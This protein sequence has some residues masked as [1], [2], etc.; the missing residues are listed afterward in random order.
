MY[1]PI[2]KYVVMKIF[3]AVG[4]LLYQNWGLEI[5]PISTDEYERC[6]PYLCSLTIMGPPHPVACEELIDA[7]NIETHFVR[8]KYNHG[9]GWM[10]CRLGSTS[11]RF[12]V[13]FIYDC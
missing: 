5:M 9:Q 6:A 3:S 13:R 12:P 10:S 11:C 4:S 8:I 2:T 7:Y 1:Y